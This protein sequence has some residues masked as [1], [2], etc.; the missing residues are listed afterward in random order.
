MGFMGI[1]A[2]LRIDIKKAGPQVGFS[3]SM[4]WHISFK[5]V[6]IRLHCAAGTRVKS[7]AES[8]SSWLF[9]FPHASK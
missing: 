2:G 1:A 9:R 4:F 3:F 5:S 6:L 7:V 8:F